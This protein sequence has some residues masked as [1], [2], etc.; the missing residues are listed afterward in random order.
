LRRAR[1]ADREPKNPPSMP[2][3]AAI[4]R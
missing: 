4:T 2:S 1:A 3:P